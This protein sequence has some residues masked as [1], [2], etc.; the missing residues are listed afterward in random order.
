MRYFLVML[1]GFAIASNGC[2]KATDPSRITSAGGSVTEIIYLLNAENYLIA[3]DV[4]SNFPPEAKE[5]P[6]IGYVRQLSAEG[7]LS[8]DP[9]IIIGE[10]DMGPPSV[11]DQI[12]GTQVEI[13]IIPEVVHMAPR[14]SKMTVRASKMTARASKMIEQMITLLIRIKTLAVKQT[15]RSEQTEKWHGGRICA[16]RTGYTRT[17]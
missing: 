1:C 4:T 10:D 13:T 17:T 6:S 15:R 3:V 7:V 11:L 9:T 14:A 5:L 16:Q 2:E 8:L 12:K